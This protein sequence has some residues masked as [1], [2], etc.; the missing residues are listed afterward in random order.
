MPSMMWHRI[1]KLRTSHHR[2][3]AC[4]K[5]KFIEKNGSGEGFLLSRQFIFVPRCAKLHQYLFSHYATIPTLPTIITLV[6]FIMILNV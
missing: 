4:H 3:L 5:A 1:M 2:V 6:P